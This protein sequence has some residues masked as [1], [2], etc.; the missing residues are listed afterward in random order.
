MNIPILIPS[1]TSLWLRV[2]LYGTWLMLRPQILLRFCR[3]MTVYIVG[4]RILDSTWSLTRTRHTWGHAIPNWTGLLTQTRFRR[5]MTVYIVGLRI[6]DWTWSLTWTGHTRGHATPDSDQ[7]QVQEHLSQEHQESAHHHPQHS[8]A[9]HHLEHLDHQHCHHQWP[10]YCHRRQHLDWH[11][12]QCHL[13]P[14]TISIG[15]TILV[16]VTSSTVLV[17]VVSSALQLPS[18]LSAWTSWLNQN[19]SFS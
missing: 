19:H 18:L 12:H 4:F 3:H 9:W 16:K 2:L 5:H 6:L 14:R 1:A 10:P 8:S 17:A 7:V 15:T 13:P 11:P